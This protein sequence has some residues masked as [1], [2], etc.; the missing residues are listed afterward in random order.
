MNRGPDMMPDISLPALVMT[1]EQP[2][3]LQQKK[4]GYTT[5][6]VSNASSPSLHKASNWSTHML[7]MTWWA[8]I[9]K[10]NQGIRW[11]SKRHAWI[12]INA[13]RIA[14]PFVEP[15]FHPSKYHPSTSTPGNHLG[16][17]DWYTSY[18][19]LTMRIPWMQIY[20]R[21]LKRWKILISTRQSN[22]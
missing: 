19:F 15:P 5:N 4:W 1:K 7:P 10:K 9:V 11:C 14:G 13:G 3:L 8:A 18:L 12:R 22:W 21:N 17:I 16:S 6:H 20:H 2:P